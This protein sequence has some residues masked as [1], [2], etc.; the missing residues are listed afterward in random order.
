MAADW[1]RVHRALQVEPDL[2]E[3]EEV[4]IHLGDRAI[5]EGRISVTAEYFNWQAGHLATEAVHPRDP[6][7]AV[8][9]DAEH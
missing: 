9:D 1:A 3:V 6:P 4:A 5:S 7:Q 2:F 8:V